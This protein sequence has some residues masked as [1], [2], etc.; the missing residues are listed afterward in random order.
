M[1]DD[2]IVITEEEEKPDFQPSLHELLNEINESTS[3]LAL[4]LADSRRVG[5]AG[6]I[7]PPL[8]RFLSLW[9][10]QGGILR[11]F[12]GF[13]FAWIAALR[14]MLLA[15]KIWHLQRHVQERQ[16]WGKGVRP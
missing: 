8:G 4:E 14:Q 5:S 15:M 16:E 1:I 11:G 2:P 6:F 9:L 7:F 10:L 12:E 13:R 3:R